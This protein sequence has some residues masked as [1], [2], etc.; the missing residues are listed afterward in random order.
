VCLQPGHP[1]DLAEDRTVRAGA[2]TGYTGGALSHMSALA[3]HRIVDVEVTRLDVTVGSTRRVRSPD[4]CGCTAPRVPCCQSELEVFGGL[5]VL[6]APG[7]PAV[8]S[9]TASCCRTSG[10]RATPRPAGRSC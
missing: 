9:S 7:L 3:V 2:A 6:T 8:A 10:S 4:G 1:A 5:H